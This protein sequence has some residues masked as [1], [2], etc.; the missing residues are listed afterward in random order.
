MRTTFLSNIY[1]IILNKYV[2]NELKNYFGKMEIKNIIKKT[3]IGYKNMIK[4]HQTIE[5]DKNTYRNL[6]VNT[7]FINV[8]K[9]I[10]NEISHD[11]YKKIQ[12]NIIKNS[13]ILTVKNK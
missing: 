7:Y 11:V 1:P 13:K 6:C 2:K 4:N 10:E 8:Y 3:N 5:I 12:E 9:N